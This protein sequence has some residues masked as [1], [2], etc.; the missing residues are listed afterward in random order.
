[1]PCLFK[2]GRGFGSIR[3]LFGGWTP[4]PGAGLAEDT[5][6][7]R[8]LNQLWWLGRSGSKLSI[9]SNGRASDFT[10]FAPAGRVAAD[11]CWDAT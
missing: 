5:A 1:V 3:L 11:V 4:D 10:P 9:E 6:R 8:E 7:H 2:S